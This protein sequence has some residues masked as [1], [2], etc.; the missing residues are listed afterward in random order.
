SRPYAMIVRWL[1]GVC[2]VAT[3]VSGGSS[4]GKL[5]DEVDTKL[6]S[7]RNVTEKTGMVCAYADFNKDRQTDVL[8]YHKG[9]LFVLLQRE[10][11]FSKEASDGSEGMTI[12]LLEEYAE[13]A[14]SVGD[15]NNDGFPDIVV[16][17]RKTKGEGDWMLKYFTFTGGEKAKEKDN[18]KGFVELSRTTKAKHQV[19]LIDVTGD[20]IHDVLGVQPDGNLLCLKGDATDPLK[21]SCDGIFPGWSGPLHPLMPILFVDVNNDRYAEVVFMKYDEK[22]GLK[23]EIWSRFDKEPEVWVLYTEQ[24]PPPPTGVSF[25]HTLSP[26]LVDIDLNMMMDV[27]VPVCKDEKCTMIDNLQVT[28]W[29]DDK[30]EAWKTVAFDLGGNTIVPEEDT[31][32]RMKAGDV[33]LDGYPDMLVT[34]G[35]LEGGRN[36][37]AII[38]NRAVN[39]DEPDKRKFEKPN[40]MLIMPGLALGMT[41]SSSFFDFAEDG[42]LDVVVQWKLR[43]GDDWQWS[44]CATQSE[45]QGD[46]TF[47]KVQTF[48]PLRDGDIKEGKGVVWGGVCVT[49]EMETTGIGED[50]RK[51]I[52]CQLPGNSHKAGLSPPF[53]LFGLGRN[54]NFIDKAEIGV[55]RATTVEDYKYH[56]QKQIVPNARMMV[57]PPGPDQRNWVLRLYLTPSSLIFSSLIVMASTC[58]ILLIV[59]LVLHL[60]EK[61]VDRVERAAQSH[62]FHF[63]AM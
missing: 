12:D 3:V 31:L 47:L 4:V 60:R 18:E 22:T 41:Q 51:A 29:K 61:K 36:Y 11:D 16:S 15:I 26:V 62:R 48:A 20:G 30:W 7:R 8:H 45:K 52:E 39:E 49:Y 2:V 14:C 58:T 57:Q 27:I 1:M 32:V 42:Y 35:S 40:Q 10:R 21:E 63:D 17:L 54:P 46:V 13:V 24:L 19:A 34:I 23:P 38:E 53:S 56:L 28:Q 5:L 25:K 44:L 9:K 43:A 55:P 50:K 37:A 33:N 6:L 59:V